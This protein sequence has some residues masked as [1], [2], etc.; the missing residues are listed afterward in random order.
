[1]LDLGEHPPSSR[2]G[3]GK[4][5]VAP[6]APEDNPGPGSLGRDELLT[7]PTPHRSKSQ[8]SLL[9]DRDRR[10]SEGGKRGKQKEKQDRSRP[11]DET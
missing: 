10:P 7:A 3:K 8:L 6:P 9:L 1:M 4:A 2:K 5:E 11:P